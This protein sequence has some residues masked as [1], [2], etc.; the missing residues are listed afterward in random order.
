MV[1]QQNKNK[2]F[3]KKGIGRSPRVP[4]NEYDLEKNIKKINSF[5]RNGRHKNRSYNHITGSKEDECQLSRDGVTIE[6]QDVSTVPLRTGDSVWEPYTRL[7]DKITDFNCR[8]AQEH[9]DLRKELEAKIKESFDACN[10]LIAK[11][12][13]KQWYVWTII[14]LCTI[15]GIWFEFS[16]SDIC[17]LPKR[18]NE[19]DN[20]LKII[21]KIDVVKNDSISTRE[22]R[23]RQAN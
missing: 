5:S 12:L 7:D 14:G 18:V 15:V 4:D 3:P 1:K 6:S 20:R 21:E 8:N 19:I 23:N 2:T 16:Y 9:T 22:N 17:Q 13:P 10:V 11:C